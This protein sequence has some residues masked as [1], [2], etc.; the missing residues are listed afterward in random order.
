LIWRDYLNAIRNPH[1]ANYRL[2]STI[3]VTAFAAGLYFR[4]NG[5]YADPSNWKA[6]SGFMFNIAVGFLILAMTP[7]SLV[8]PTERNV[9]LKEESAKLYGTFSYFLSRNAV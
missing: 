7:V 5:D 6:V 9:F 8:F 4:F 1:L 3:I 2:L